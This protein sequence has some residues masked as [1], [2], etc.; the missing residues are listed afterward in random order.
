MNKS[1]LVFAVLLFIAGPVYSQNDGDELSSLRIETGYAFTGSGDLEGY[2]FYNE[3][4]R[5]LG[6][7]FKIGPTVGFL[8]FFRASDDVQ[9]MQG[10]NCIS[11]DLTGYFYPVK[12][13][14][15]DIEAEAG[16]YLRNWYWFFATGPDQTYLVNGVTFGPGSYYDYYSTAPGYIISIGKVI[17]AGYRLGINIRGVYQNDTND[18][19]SV[20]A[21]IGQNIRL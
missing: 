14:L 3:Y 17:K 10:A 18:D 5:S 11:F 7:R 6:D 1:T 20:T 16:F 13:K 15:F 12:T 21:R 9:L 2:C 19:N 8:N 4:L